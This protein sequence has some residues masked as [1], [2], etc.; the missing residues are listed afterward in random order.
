M[1]ADSVMAWG[2]G[3]FMLG[4]GMVVFAIGVCALALAIS[5]IREGL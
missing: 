5:A 1:T 3:L 4:T 2:V